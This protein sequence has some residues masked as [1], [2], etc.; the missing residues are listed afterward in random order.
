MLL[1]FARYI[2]SISFC[3]ILTVHFLCFRIV[4]CM[5]MIYSNENRLWNCFQFG[6]LG[7]TV[8]IL[9]YMSAHI[10]VGSIINNL[11]H[12][13]WLCSNLVNNTKLFYESLPIYNSTTG[14]GEFLVVVS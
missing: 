4:D 1:L 6:P 12:N 3:S 9:V 8:N 11:G 2:L 14:I 13:N 10:S 7:D 5:N